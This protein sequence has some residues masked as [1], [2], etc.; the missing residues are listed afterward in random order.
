FAFR[1]RG[2]RTMPGAVLLPAAFD[3]P[4]T[5]DH[6]LACWRF[7]RFGHEGSLGGA[8]SMCLMAGARRAIVI[9]RKRG[10][11]AQTQLRIPETP[12][13]ARQEAEE[14]SQATRARGREESHPRGDARRSFRYIANRK[15]RRLK[16]LQASSG[17]TTTRRASGSLRPT[18]A[19][20]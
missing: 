17:S 7:V 5:D 9:F 18:P 10:V 11:D 15:S 19:A 13:R 14:G 3:L 4:P 16:W 8:S 12:A 1:L 6:S 20:P 2:R